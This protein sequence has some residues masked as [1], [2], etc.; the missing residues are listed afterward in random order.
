MVESHENPMLRPDR[1]PA[2]DRVPETPEG[3]VVGWESL[4]QGRKKL[5]IGFEGQVYQLRVTRNGKLI[6]T[7]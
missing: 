6:L 3:E 2:A 1:E 4:A 5:L 7:K